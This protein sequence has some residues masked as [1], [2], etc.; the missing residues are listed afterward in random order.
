[1]DAKS[2]YP[3]DFTF[4]PDGQFV[5]VACAG[6]PL[7]VW[8]IKEPAPKLSSGSGSLRLV[9][10]FE[11]VT[12]QSQN[13][14]QAGYDNFALAFWPNDEGQLRVVHSMTP[15]GHAELRD[16]GTGQKLPV[17]LP[18]PEGISS[19]TFSADGDRLLVG[20]ETAPVEV[21][22]WDFANAKRE[23]MLRLDAVG[24]VF[25]LQ[26]DASSN[27]I[28]AEHGRGQPRFSKWR[29][30]DGKELANFE[31]ERGTNYGSAVVAVRRDG[32]MI[33]FCKDGRAE[34]YNL[35][36]G[37]RIAAEL[38]TQNRAMWCA[39]SPAGKYLATWGYDGVAVVSDAASGK[40]I[41]RFKGRE[42]LSAAAFSPDDRYL[43]T[44]EF[45]SKK[46]GAV[47][48]WDMESGRLVAKDT[49]PVLKDVVADPNSEMWLHLGEGVF[50]REIA[51]APDGRHF[52]L[53]AAG[54]PLC[55]WRIEENRPQAVAATTS[56]RLTLAKRFDTAVATTAYNEYGMALSP[57]DR[58]LVHSMTHRGRLERIDLTTNEVVKLPFESPVAVNS[59]AISEDSEQLVVG[60]KTGDVH[61]FWMNGQAEPVKLTTAH[62]LVRQVAFSGQ[63]VLA[64][65]RSTGGNSKATGAG[66]IERW[67]RGTWEKDGSIVCS[68]PGI[69]SVWFSTVGQRAAA[70]KS[71][72][73][74]VLDLE[75]QTTLPVEF[76]KHRPI[77]VKRKNFSNTWGV[78]GS[79]DD[80]R[81]LSW[82]YDDRVV[83]WDIS[84]GKQTLPAFESNATNSGAV[85][86][87][88]FSPDGRWI[89]VTR[90]RHLVGPAVPGQL[91]VRDAQTG[92]I[93]AIAEIPVAANT[94]SSKFGPAFANKLA[95][96]RDG[97]TIITG[98]CSTPIC[99]WKLEERASAGLLSRP[100]LVNQFD[101]GSTNNP[102][103]YF[104][105]LSPDAAHVSY[106]I[107]ENEAPRDKVR[108]K[109]FERSTGKE[110]VL[111]EQMHSAVAMDY[112]A[113]GSRFATGHSIG[114][115]KVY[116]W[117]AT[118]RELI[119]EYT[120]PPTPGV[121][122][123]SLSD[124]GSRLLAVAC[125]WS[126]G[127]ATLY[128]WDTR[129]KKKIAEF[130]LNV[131]NVS[132]GVKIDASN[133]GRILAV[134]YASNIR[135]WDVDTG[136]ESETRFNAHPVGVQDFFIDLSP[137]GDRLAVGVSP[138]TKSPARV[139][140]FETATGREIS[141]HTYGRRIFGVRFSPDAR[142]V[143][144]CADSSTQDDFMH[145]LDAS[146]GKE[147]IH[148][149]APLQDETRED[150]RF[151]P[152]VR[153][154]SFSRNGR[155]LLTAGPNTPV[156]VWKIEK[157]QSAGEWTDLLSGIDPADAA[158]RGWAK[159]DDGWRVT[160]EKAI[161]V[162]AFKRRPI[163]SYKLQAT[164]RFQLVTGAGGVS[165]N[166]FNLPVG[167]RSV[168]V[169]LNGTG[170]A[171]RLINAKLAQ[172]PA[173]LA[174]LG[175]FEKG[176]AYRF[177]F[178]VE[179][180]GDKVRISVD[181]DSQRLIE[182]SGPI[183][184]LSPDNTWT[185]KARDGDEKALG[186]FSHRG[187][188]RLDSLRLREIGGEWTS[189]FDG[190]TLDGWESKR[191]NVYWRV[192]EDGTLEGK[193]PTEPRRRFTGFNRR[194]LAKRS[195]GDFSLRFEYSRNI[196]PKQHLPFVFRAKTTGRGERNERAVRREILNGDQYQLHFPSGPFSPRDSEAGSLF[197]ASWG[198]KSP[199]PIKR[200]TE[201]SRRAVWERANGS[202]WHEAEITVRGKNVVATVNGIE[203][204]SATVDHLD[205]GS[206]GF[207]APLTGS[208]KIRNVRI[209]D[210]S[211]KVQG[212]P[213]Q[214]VKENP[215]ERAAAA[216]LLG[217]TKL[218][219]GIEVQGEYRKVESADD[220]PAEPF[221]VVVVDYH[222]KQNLTVDDLAKVAEFSSL[223]H[224]SIGYAEVTKEMLKHVGGMRALKSLH[225]MYC[226][227]DDAKMDQLKGLTDLEHLLLGG[228]QVSD[229]G[230]QHLSE[231][232]SLVRL[233]L[234]D[235]KVSGSNLTALEGLERLNTL[236]LGG[237]SFTDKSAALASLKKMPVLQHLHLTQAGLNEKEKQEFQAA[238]L[239][240]VIRYAT[241]ATD[242]DIDKDGKD[243]ASQPLP[244]D[245]R[246]AAVDLL[247]R[248]GAA[249]TV[250]VQGK[251]S[252]VKS[253]EQLPADAFTV[254]WID[255]Y[256]RQNLTE[257]DL[258]NVARFPSLNILYLDDAQL[259][260]KMLR[261]I[262]GLRTLARLRLSGCD[263]GGKELGE[264]L[265]GLT[266]LS[267]LAL[268]GTQVSDADL[269]HLSGMQSL[270]TL[271]LLNTNVTG[272]NL[273]VLA[274][275][276]SLRTLSVGGMKFTE[277]TAALAS[278]KKM[279][280][281]T[282]FGIY[283]GLTLTDQEEAD[284]R[285]ALPKCTIELR[286]ATED[287]SEEDGTD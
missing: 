101:H 29:A 141:S 88:T 39:Y 179:P 33:A 24:T 105:V 112:N 143:V 80:T 43:V 163:G 199:V 151:G 210:L 262:G 9:R 261:H 1:K 277:K 281:L 85:P 247:R 18:L 108:M 287:D 48:V 7:T 200:A 11:D 215:A 100:R 129:T 81:L 275:I 139:A 53:A 149:Q 218:T 41:W 196:G 89:V 90:A 66:S 2:A 233:G 14:R 161:D 266:K 265:K 50:A 203:L 206:I 167:D 121:Q 119:D 49:I 42:S 192:A 58:W 176:R 211:A 278:L 147:L 107:F 15:D 125:K 174:V 284:L 109:M 103:S 216:F 220:L 114:N 54:S 219:I 239:D 153:F 79:P 213:T 175:Q 68:I 208:V 249:I 111:P 209:Q 224:L 95:I 225:L 134:A 162:L 183:A 118:T 137:S 76:G 69:G 280:Q 44:G 23:P 221:T 251:Q 96:S 144:V 234:F 150:S 40:E 152:M 3:R 19:A 172:Q 128:A 55:V 31:S 194:L 264:L 92:K 274:G 182:W 190:K 6:S 63:Y 70:P 189:L 97:R 230:L 36:V 232:Q 56:G 115:G 283:G 138:G 25:G 17:P 160:T 154:L 229:A 28:I 126:G 186:I 205:T 276:K 122:W 222:P 181:V 177:E 250:E 52:A 228:T 171:L 231:M 127:K 223:R 74:E 237:P 242:D 136:R 120:T 64:A 184:S 35:N 158:E 258:A 51:F 67:K 269:Q 47:T 257:V 91:I 13:G 12:L 170:L 240:C 22:L 99:V 238:L 204:L 84:T 202:D 241:A 270:V 124:D 155:H 279:T 46:P 132:H 185:L 72:T 180:K 259:T 26:F 252:V 156:C 87:A 191:D 226:N 102:N 27:Y 93:A 273:E 57:D 193:S 60:T 94:R 77:S 113:D 197:T 246:A 32:N 268:D 146:S 65:S 169:R 130:K 38:P 116:L 78:S 157:R 260:D 245:Q 272:S 165:G 248:P 16:V 282:K 106:Q 178:L 133:D 187:G 34:R 212:I 117:D 198:T 159:T 263:I 61:I 110:I 145:L 62:G 75:K 164:M 188:T 244:G 71:D 267:W 98:G 104:A 253:G 207:L 37:E 201:E 142:Y 168:S 236:Q 83:V 217:R 166:T 254:V 286:A 255:L 256:G 235:S 243:D 59:I 30:S 195:F 271:N 82:G 20:T 8:R 73:L 285:A 5:A 214:P 123:V 21:T 86:A 10:K 227:I 140:V 131:A 173:P 148:W 4:T 135:L 45:V